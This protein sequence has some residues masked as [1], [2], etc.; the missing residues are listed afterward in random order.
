MA[1]AS[2]PMYALP[3]LL[4]ATDEWW[5][6]LARAFIAEGLEDVPRSLSD[7]DMRAYWGDPDLLFG[8]TCGYP[9]TH[10]YA[11]RLRVVATPAYAAKGCV[12]SNYSSAI[13]VR[14][15]E[16]ATSLQE[17][18]GRRAVINAHDS[19]SGYSALRH[20]VAPLAGGD[21]FFADVQVSGGHR[22]SMLAVAEGR[23][24]I[25]AVDCVTFAL[26]Q[27]LEPNLTGALR[28]LAFSAEAPALP[29]V[30]AVGNS[31][32]QVARL[33]AGLRRA[34]A[35]PDLAEVREVLLI[36]GVEVLPD[37]AYDRIMAMET[38]A[39]GLGYAE[40]R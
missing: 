16:S 37:G 2:L 17:L 29:Y 1:I 28:V 8:Q 12:G 36:A 4:E 19:Q 7:G 26:F 38:E 14:T 20:A 11:G 6:G 3:G 13:L 35:D 33:R 18:K 31:E 25:A 27:H 5:A 30:T 21:S 23:A 34:C 32:D 39:M 24:D 10:D 22:A 15:D 9:L 40:V